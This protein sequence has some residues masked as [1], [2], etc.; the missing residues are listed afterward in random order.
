LFERLRGIPGVTVYPSVTNF[1]LFSVGAR[2]VPLYQH[3]AANEIA[4]RNV[5]GLP[6][7]AGHLRVTIGD[8]SQNELFAA[9]VA[10]FLR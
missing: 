6:L 7:L 8:P 9:T 2:A 1:L 10:A 3:L 4:V 5:S